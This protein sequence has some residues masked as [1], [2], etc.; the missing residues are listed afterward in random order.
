MWKKIKDWLKG[1]Y[2]APKR[3]K[4]LENE[5]EELRQAQDTVQQPITAADI[6]DE[7]YNGKKGGGE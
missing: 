3:I 1:I 6:M 5:L 4:Q 7:W 2:T